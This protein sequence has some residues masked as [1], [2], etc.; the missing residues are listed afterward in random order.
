VLFKGKFTVGRQVYNPSGQADRTKQFYY[1][2]DQDWRLPLAGVA[3]V[4]DDQ[5]QN[6]HVETWIKG[7]IVDASKI[8]GYLFFAS[9]ARRRR[10]S[11]RS[12]TTRPS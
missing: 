11:N 8:R 2:V 1:Y 9:F 5:V 4:N 12:S 10:R 6:L 7:P 3:A